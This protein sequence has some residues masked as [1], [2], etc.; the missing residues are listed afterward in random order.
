MA[1]AWT[2]SAWASGRRPAPS[3]RAMADEI[4]PP[5]APADIICISIS[6]GKTSA[7]PASASVPSLATKYVSTSP[8][9]ACTNMT[10]TFGAASRSS[11]LAIGPS[12]SARVRA[13]KRGAVAGHAAS[14]LRDPAPAR[15]L[16]PFGNITAS[17]LRPWAF[18]DGSFLP[19]ERLLRHDSAVDGEDRPGRPRGLIRR[20]MEHGLGDL[21][22]P[23]EPTER[24]SS[25]HHV[26]HRGV[27]QP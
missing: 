16:L 21:V 10:S 4:P 25:L 22:R 20:E 27:R 26:S 5:I 6:T 9:D 1:S 12:S 24:H 7:T 13:S 17:V 8:T 2:T 11:V 3:A 23:A 15:T 19:A 18:M 14:L